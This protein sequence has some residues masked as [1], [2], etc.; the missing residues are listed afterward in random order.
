MMCGLI[1]C[2][3]HSISIIS[4]RLQIAMTSLIAMPEPS[5]YA[6][7]QSGND[8]AKSNVKYDKGKQKLNKNERDR[9]HWVI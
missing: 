8:E 5:H 4:D 2:L 3:E 6:K 1:S 7:W 9:K